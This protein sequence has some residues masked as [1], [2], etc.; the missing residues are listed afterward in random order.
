MTLKL[1]PI[2]F[3][4]ILCWF[5]GGPA[6]TGTADDYANFAAQ[7]IHESKDADLRKN[8]LKLINR[9]RS[10]KNLHPLTIDSR[11]NKAA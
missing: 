4:C 1:R 11:L 3:L 10:G 9:E 7:E 6:A 2:F 8:L 5:V